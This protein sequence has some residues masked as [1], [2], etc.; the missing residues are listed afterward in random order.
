MK[1]NQVVEYQKDEV[2]QAYKTHMYTVSQKM[3]TMVT[4]G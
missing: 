1:M 3:K 2:L 4:E